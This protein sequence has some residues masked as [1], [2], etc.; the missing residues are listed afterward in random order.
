VQVGGA[1]HHRWVAVGHA[2]D[3]LTGVPAAG[4]VYEPLDALPDLLQA[5]VRRV[6]WVTVEVEPVDLQV[7]VWPPLPAR[8]H[9]V[10]QPGYPQAGG[11]VGHGKYAARLPGPQPRR[12]VNVSDGL[13]GK[14]TGGDLRLLQAQIGQTEARQP[15]I[16]DVAG[17]MYFGV[18]D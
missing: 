4:Q 6:Q 16:Q 3:R 5:L 18:P 13:L 2:D 7:R 17:V 1:G 9:F 8:Q 15:A 12:G 14:R 10:K 11:R